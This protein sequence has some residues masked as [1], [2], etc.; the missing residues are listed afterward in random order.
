M[1]SAAPI[2]SPSGVSDAIQ[3]GDVRFNQIIMKGN[4]FCDLYECQVRDSTG[5]RSL[6]INVTAKTGDINQFDDTSSD[7][8]ADM[9]LQKM[10]GFLDEL[11]ATIKPDTTM[12][13]LVSTSSW[14]DYPFVRFS[15]KPD[16]APLYATQDG[17]SHPTLTDWSAR[18]PGDTVCAILEPRAWCKD[19]AGGVK[20]WVKKAVI[21]E[22]GVD[23]DPM[24]AF[25][26]GDDLKNTLNDAKALAHSVSTA[27]AKS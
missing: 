26:V 2:Y 5:W 4:A 27:I 22:H 15:W 16:R 17:E 19:G 21:T 14:V 7:I 23:K 25:K 12:K 13:S 20:M 8:E 10:C 1:A 3:K 6:L 24:A 18:G 11:A 9:D